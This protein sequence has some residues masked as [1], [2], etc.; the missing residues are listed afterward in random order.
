MSLRLPLEEGE[1][2]IQEV[3]LALFQHLRRGKSRENL[4]GW[5]F[6]VGHNLASKRRYA[7]ERQ[8]LHQ[9]ATES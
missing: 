9:P 3:F 1:E 6:R 5:I 4:R 7:C 2:V 8:L